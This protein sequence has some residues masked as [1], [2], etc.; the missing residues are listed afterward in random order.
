M[1]NAFWGLTP[2][3]WT[4]VAAIGTTLSALAAVNLVEEKE[5]MT[6]GGPKV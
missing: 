2:A 4:A 3:G 5:K 1:P 6:S